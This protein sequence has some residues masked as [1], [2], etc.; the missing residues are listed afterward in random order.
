[1][2]A[3]SDPVRALLAIGVAA[4]VFTA[5]MYAITPLAEWYAD[6]RTR[7]INRKK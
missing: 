4:A 1:M 5:V 7:K 6:R 3:L 2:L